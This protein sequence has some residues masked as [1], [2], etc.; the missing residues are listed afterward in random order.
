VGLRPSPGP[1][2]CQDPGLFGSWVHDSR[3]GVWSGPTQ[4]SGSQCIMSCTEV[5][6][7]AVRAL[8]LDARRPKSLYLDHKCIPLIKWPVLTRGVI[9]LGVFLT[10]YV[11]RHFFAAVMTSKSQ[12][13]KGHDGAV[14]ALKVAIELLNLAK[15]TCCIPPA[16]VAFGSVSGLLSMIRVRFPPLCDIGFLVHVYPRT[17]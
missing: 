4:R 1:E 3:C 5:V 2:I 14:L 12:R 11:P 17:L 10:A 6:P 15:D 9:G 8:P 13:P 16:Q 7:L